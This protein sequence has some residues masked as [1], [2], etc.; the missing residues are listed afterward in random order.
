MS[1]VSSNEDWD[2]NKIAGDNDM[3]T[4][5]NIDSSP[6]IVVPC[7]QVHLGNQMATTHNG[8]NL[9]YNEPL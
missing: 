6:N 1:P 4:N 9:Q 8:I 5:G 7:D 3:D 2:L